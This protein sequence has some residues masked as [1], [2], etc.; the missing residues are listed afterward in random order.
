MDITQG[1]ATLGKGTETTDL[2]QISCQLDDLQRR[3]S[4]TIERLNAHAVRIF[5]GAPAELRS[6]AETAVPAMPYSIDGI[7]QRVANCA[8]GLD[9]VAEA[10]QKFARL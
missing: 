8:D 2:E 10:A 1:Q 4:I 6:A 9:R 5:D 3:I 7:K